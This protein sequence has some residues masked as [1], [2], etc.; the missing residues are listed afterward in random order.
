MGLE[1]DRQVQVGQGLRL[2]VDQAKVLLVL[3]VGV[4]AHKHLAQAKV[5]LPPQEM[6]QP[7]V[8]AQEVAKLPKAGGG[9]GLLRQVALDLVKQ[10]PQEMEQLLAVD[11]GVAKLALAE[12]A[13]KQVD[14]EVDRLVLQVLAQLQEAAQDG[15]QLTSPEIY[16]GN[17][18]EVKLLLTNYF[19]FINR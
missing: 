11:Q 2:V 14:Q 12:E 3:G 18:V 5:P 15:D 9:E 17:A 7:Q 16:E 13:L 19:L 1:V 4:V 10:V 8:P 6:E